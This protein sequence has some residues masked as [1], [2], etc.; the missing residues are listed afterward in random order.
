MTP[1]EERLLAAVAKAV[2]ERMQYL[3]KRLRRN[4][5]NKSTLQRGLTGR[6]DIKLSTMARIFDALDADVTIVVTPRGGSRG[7]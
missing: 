4:G 5:I 1:C 6:D 7:K 3:G 2:R